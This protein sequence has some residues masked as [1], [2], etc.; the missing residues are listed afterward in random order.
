M[1]QAR[2]LFFEFSINWFVSCLVSYMTQEPCNIGF[3]VFFKINNTTFSSSKTV[4]L[5]ADSVAQPLVWHSLSLCT[6]F[7]TLYYLCIVNQVLKMTRYKEKKKNNIPTYPF[8]NWW[9]GAQQTMNVS[10]WPCAF[11]SVPIQVTIVPSG[12]GLNKVKR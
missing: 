1:L 7:V 10:G 8:W 5:I 12:Q 4:F 9:V 11:C 2:I 3:C 6:T